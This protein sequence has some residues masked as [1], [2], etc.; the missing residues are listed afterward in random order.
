[1]REKKVRVAILMPH[2]DFWEHTVGTPLREEQGRLLDEVVHELGEECDIAFATVSSSADHSVIAARAIMESV[3]VAL[4]LSSV[5]APPI[6]AQAFLDTLP[7]AVPVVWAL[8]E[9]AFRVESTYD[10]GAITQH[11]ATVGAP[12]VTSLLAKTGRPYEVVLGRIGDADV[13]QRLHTT[14]RI[15]GAAARVRRARIGIVEGPVS[16]YEHIRVDPVSLRAEIGIE[17]VHIPA[18]EFR[19]AYLSVPL[20]QVQQLIDEAHFTFGLILKSD[21]KDVVERTMRAAAAVEILCSVHCLDAGAFNCHVP[22]IRFDDRVGIAPCYGLG[23]MTSLGVP[24]TCTGDVPTAIAMYTVKCLGKPALYHE[25]EAIDYKSGEFIVANSGEHDLGWRR[26]GQQAVLRT[27]EWFRGRDASCGLCVAMGLE[28][29]P[30]TLVAFTERQAPSC[31]YTFITAKG[32]LSGRIFPDT[33]TTNGSFRFAAM[34]PTHA[35]ER[36]VQAGAGHHSC[37]AKGNIGEHI[38]RIAHLLGIWWQN[39]S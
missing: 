11:G 27:N 37:L 33:G 18:A 39:V 13:M 19:D 1:M 25:L 7:Q 31:R 15:A 16:G 5:A 4:I 36:W 35:W 20:S 28:A 24:W 10:H 34:D 21:E 8:H 23:R 12:M 14:V 3:D 26:P 22:E 30:A 9:R 6:I 2:W 17:V 32:H 38:G 29:G